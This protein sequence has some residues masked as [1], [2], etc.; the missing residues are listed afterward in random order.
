MFF[1]DDSWIQFLAD[2]QML[3]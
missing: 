2:V 1:A 3:V